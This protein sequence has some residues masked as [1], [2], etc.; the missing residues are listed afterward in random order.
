MLSKNEQVSFLRLYVFS[1]FL[2]ACSQT[3]SS[4]V[5][6]S[7][8]QGLYSQFT[9]KQSFKCCLET[10]APPHNKKWCTSERKGW[11]LPWFCPI[12]SHLPPFVHITFKIIL[13]VPVQDA[14]CYHLSAGPGWLEPKKMGE[15]I[16]LC[17]IATLLKITSAFYQLLFYREHLV[18]KSM[19]SNTCQGYITTKKHS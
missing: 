16:E 1:T 15:T 9:A 14:S 19:P 6:S 18:R 7:W 5:P 17:S 12:L 10:W 13:Q 8:H 3:S 2:Y 11:T 4:K